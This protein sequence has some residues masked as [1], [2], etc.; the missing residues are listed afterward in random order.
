MMISPEMYRADKIISPMVTAHASTLPNQHDEDRFNLYKHDARHF[1]FCVYDGHCG[2]SFL[3]HYTFT[4][5]L[6]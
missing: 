4:H 1:S 3:L 6:Y 5:C 2:G